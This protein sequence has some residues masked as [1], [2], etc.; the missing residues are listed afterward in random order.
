[1]GIMA[2]TSVYVWIA[3]VSLIKNKEHAM[4]VPS[5][6]MPDEG[7]LN[8]KVAR[9]PRREE[10]ISR[11]RVERAGQAGPPSTRINYN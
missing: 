5:K 8:A 11:K 3:R 7:I 9:V 1:M 4:S 10:G 2:L 6:R